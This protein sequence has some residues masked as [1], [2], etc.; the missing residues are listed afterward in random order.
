[1]IGLMHSGGSV[2]I[3]FAW[4]VWFLSCGML[5]LFYGAGIDLKDKTMFHGFR[6]VKCY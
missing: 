6:E 5:L 2:D 4:F 3:F 1:M